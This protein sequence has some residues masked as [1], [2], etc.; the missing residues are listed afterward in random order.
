[1]AAQSKRPITASRFEKPSLKENFIYSLY[2]YI[3][4]PLPI[5]DTYLKTSIIYT[6]QCTSIL[7]NVLLVGVN[8]LEY[9]TG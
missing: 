4:V 6:I 9:I 3:H 5:I 8:V 2:N 1:M 7:Y